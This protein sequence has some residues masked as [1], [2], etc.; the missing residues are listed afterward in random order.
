M[1]GTLEYIDQFGGK[2]FAEVPFND[3]DNVLMC[4]IFYMPLERVVS[5]SFDD[6]P[7][8]FSKAANDLFA[9]MGYKY[10][11]L[12]LMITKAASIKIMKMASQKR[13]SEMKL[14]AVKEVFESDPAVQFAAGTFIL[15]DGKLLVV[16]RGTD[17]SIIGWKEDLDIYVRNGIPSYKLGVDYLENL[18]EKYDGDII[19][20]G[21][22][23]GGNVALY[24]VLNSSEKVRSRVTALYN[25]D[26][27]GYHD[28]SVFQD[29]KYDDLLPK[30]R[31][32]VPHSSF[33]GMLLA[34][35]YDFTAVK[36]TRH[37]GPIQHDMGTW[38]IENGELVTK[39]DVD[40]LAKITDVALSNMLLNVT[41]AQSA[42][43]DFVGNELI[44][45]TSQVYLTE[46]AKNIVPSVKGAMQAWQNIEPKVREEFKGAFSG[47]GKIIKNT[48]KNIKTEAIPQAAKNASI[49]VRRVAAR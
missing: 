36:S 13:Y 9:K 35:D 14:V 10:Q 41:D 15:P 20:C 26:G 45:G 22:S 43:V 29:G 12:G 8:D 47:A 1:A 17:D 34:H 48:V 44:K 24:S 18:A 49:L 46:F 40:V 30:Y 32:I 3:A 16:F 19:V 11:K 42:V 23:K 33:V 4:E 39:P 27:P 38:Q 25:N 2:S 28:Y 7:V 6:E 5:E 37:L 31:H 21:H